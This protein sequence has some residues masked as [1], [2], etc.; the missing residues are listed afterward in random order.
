MNTTGAYISKLLYRYE[1]VIVPNFGAFLTR[2]QPASIDEATHTFDPPKK[3]ISFNRQL[4]TND[5]LLAN[6]IATKEGISYEEAISKIDRYVF[7]IQEQMRKGETIEISGVGSFYLEE[8]NTLQFEP[9]SS[10]NYLTETFGFSSFVSPKITREVTRE[11]LKE[12]IEEL[13][14][15][16]PIAFT[17]EKRE[18]PTYLKYAKYAAAAVIAIAIGSPFVINELDQRNKLRQ[19]QLTSATNEAI[20]NKIQ[21]A[22]FEIANP[23]PA[24]SLNVIKEQIE[25]VKETISEDIEAIETIKFHIVAGAFRIPENAEN[26]VQE[27]K[28]QGYDSYL[29]GVNKYGLHQVAYSGFADREEAV[30][31][32]RKIKKQETSKA[33]M[34]VK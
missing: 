18:Q 33:W 15:K 9:N 3:V 24:I 8:E 30:K 22:T 10:Q 23:L 7:S 12:E 6:F 27:L 29:I 4:Q 16:A 25:E 20:E 19:Q 32:L 34:L 13:E 26:K 31:A 14:E 11:V 17:P 5:G 21:E 28:D 1:C 2:R